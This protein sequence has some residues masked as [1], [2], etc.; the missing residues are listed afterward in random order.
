MSY[1]NILSRVSNTKNNERQLQ[2]KYPLKQGSRYGFYKAITSV[3]ESINQN[4]KFLLLTEPGEWPM[5]PDLGIGL[6]KYLFENYNSEMLGNISSVIQK[7]L[8]RF[9]PRVK[10]VDANFIFSDEDKD[11]NI[12]KLNIKYIILGST[13]VISRIEMD[14]NGYLNITDESFNKVSE[15]IGEII[16]LTSNETQI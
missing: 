6:K 11:Q 9:L 15:N 4:F 8:T 12:I 2:P 5:Q 10:L 16:G 3:E 7:Q 1:I 13:Q 14:E